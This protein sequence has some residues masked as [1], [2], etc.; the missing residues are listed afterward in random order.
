MA[1]TP[2]SLARRWRMIRSCRWTVAIAVA[3][4]TMTADRADAQTPADTTGRFGI[5][6]QSSWPSY[7]ISGIVDVTNRISA[8]AVVGA[9]GT[10]S[11]FS[12]RG[13][14]RFMREEIY[15]LYGFGTGGVWR[16]NHVGLDE[17][18]LGLGGGA[19]M[20]LDW[21]RILGSEETRFP[22]IFS[23]LELGIVHA[24][25]DVY[26]FSSFSIGGGIHYR[27]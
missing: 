21:R 6:F 16:Y 3:I 4:V 17:S 10:V 24:N 19:G 18:V 26:N 2:G 15:N 1:G 11:N 13:I 23:S 8:Q 9:F 5:G 22:P 7:G 27:F 14:Y 12:G 25:F 20:E